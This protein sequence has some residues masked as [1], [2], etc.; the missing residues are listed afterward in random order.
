LHDWRP[1][2]KDMPLQKSPF[3]VSYDIKISERGTTRDQRQ[4]RRLWTSYSL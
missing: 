3:G 1:L 4:W 2:C